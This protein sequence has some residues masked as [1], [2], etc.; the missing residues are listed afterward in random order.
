M[1]AWVKDQLTNYLAQAAA[2]ISEAE[3]TSGASASASAKVTKVKSISGDA[4]IVMVRKLPR[5]GYNFEADLSA[6]LKLKSTA[7]GAEEQNVSTVLRLPEILDSVAP[8][9]LKVDAQWKGHGPPEEFR[10]TAEACIN[11][12][13]QSVRDQ[14][15]S[16][17]TAYQEKR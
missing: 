9:D 16:F 13:R 8:Q 5:H 3:L 10:A 7:E 11:K 1:T 14:V 4:Q 2:S 15:A 17:R 6:S 12:L